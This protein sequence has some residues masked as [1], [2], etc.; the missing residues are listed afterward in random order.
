MANFHQ[1]FKVEENYFQR[2]L[3]F[4][5]SLHFLLQKGIA[6]DFM[7]SILVKSKLKQNLTNQYYK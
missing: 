6:F 7:K 1:I 5:M 3:G 2:S 4:Y